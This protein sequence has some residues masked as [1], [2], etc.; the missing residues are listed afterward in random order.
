MMIPCQV[1]IPLPSVTQED[2]SLSEM[3]RSVSQFTFYIETIK[4]YL[5]LGKILSTVYKPWSGQG[6]N[7]DFESQESG[8][9]AQPPDLEAIMSL[10]E[11]LS[12]FED[13]LAPYL[14][15]ERGINTRDSLPERY[16][17]II[18]RQTNV[19]YARLV[20]QTRLMYPTYQYL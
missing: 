10:D 5:I 1:T 12:N 3:A 18:Q 13:A 11:D 2:E 19:L 9:H 20:P 6:V 17:W 16:Q 15:W 7:N 4:L 8:D 14:H